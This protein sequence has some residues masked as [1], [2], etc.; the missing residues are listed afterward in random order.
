MDIR[1]SLT[2]ETEVPP[3]RGTTRTTTAFEE[4]DEEEEGEGEGEAKA[5]KKLVSAAAESPPGTLPLS[6]LAAGLQR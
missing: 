5:R 1:H 3:A 4:G 6:P 2:T